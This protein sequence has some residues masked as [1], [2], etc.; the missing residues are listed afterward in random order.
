M[1]KDYTTPD[2]TNTEQGLIVNN[3]A[4]D[5]FKNSLQEY[6]I[7]IDSLDRDFNKYKNPFEYRI[8]FNDI[9]NS[10]D[11]VILRNFDN[12]K[13][14]KMDTCILPSYYYFVKQDTSLNN[15][16]FDIIK[17]MN[18]VDNP[19]NSTFNLSS[20]DV[21]G[22]YAIIDIVD[23]LSADTTTYTRYIKWCDV[24]EYPVSVDNVFEMSFTF[25]SDSGNMPSDPHSSSPAY[26]SLNSITRY[27][28]KQYNIVND[29]YTLLHIEEFN[30]TIEN[31]TSDTIKKAFSVLFFD[32]CQSGTNYVSSKY[33][34]KVFK[35]SSLGK[36]NRLSISFK[37]FNGHQ[38]K[39]SASDYT[40][41]HISSNKQCDCTTTTNGYFNRDYRCSC[42]YF[43]NKYYQKFQNLIILKVGAYESQIDKEIF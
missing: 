37:N 8:N 18:L 36:I 26:P 2:Y 21:S 25:N 42:T 17:T 20:Y 23:I 6:T 15:V 24:Q 7:I 16:D 28:M 12:V 29:K 39:N 4:E 31:T 19:R 33:T 41:Y 30:N 14:I 9:P 11:A 43:R 5:P 34:D 1:L 10:S 22:N 32:G 3:L 38:L 35:T 40:D 27:K 13:Y